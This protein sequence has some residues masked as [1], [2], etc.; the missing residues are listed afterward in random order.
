MKIIPLL[1]LITLT[2]STNGQPR[3]SDLPFHF[4]ATFCPYE[5]LTHVIV[6][7]L[8]MQAMDRFNVLEFDPDALEYET[9][10]VFEL[11]IEQFAEADR[12]TAVDSLWEVR[13][14]VQLAAQYRFFVF[15][16]VHNI[17]EQWRR[18]L[19]IMKTY[20]DYEV[21]VALSKRYGLGL[22]ITQLVELSRCAR[23]TCSPKRSTFGLSQHSSP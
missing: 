4:T 1:M 17:S 2:T 20:I 7:D 10:A 5:L 23:H 8:Q 12:Q 18:Q 11:L 19:G 13:E 22:D 3:Y 21:Q 14:A 6:N 16:D 9:D 15:F